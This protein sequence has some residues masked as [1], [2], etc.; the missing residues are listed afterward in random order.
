MF[1][2]F[3]SVVGG[4]NLL[5][6]HTARAGHSGSSTGAVQPP[7]DSCPRWS[8][9]P[10]E[11]ANNPSHPEEQWASQAADPDIVMLQD[12]ATTG[13]GDYDRSF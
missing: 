5:S 9:V 4:K 6:K 10:D 13:R 3:C 12:V 1:S 7:A 11:D 2:E 8:A